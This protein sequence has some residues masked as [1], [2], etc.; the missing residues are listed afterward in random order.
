[1]PQAPG[2]SIAEICTRPGTSCHRAGIET[3]DFR[4]VPPRLALGEQIV[5]AAGKS[6]QRDEDEGADEIPT[7]STPHAR[8][9]RGIPLRTAQ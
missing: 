2:P 6:D 1:M 3:S 9:M 7:H 8:T 4:V 5:A